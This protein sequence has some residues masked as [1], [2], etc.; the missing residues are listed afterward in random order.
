MRD[1]QPG[2]EERQAP[3]QEFL[4]VHPSRSPSATDQGAARQAARLQRRAGAAD[5]GGLPRPVARRRGYAVRAACHVPQLPIP[6][7]A[8][9]SARA[10]AGAARQT[11]PAAN[12][13]IPEREAHRRALGAHGAVSSCRASSSPR[14][15]G[16][17]G[18]PSAQSG[19]PGEPAAR[20]AALL[21]SPSR[22]TKHGGYWRPW[23]ATAS[24]RSS[25]WRWASG[26]ARARHAAFSGAMWTSTTPPSPSAASFSARHGKGSCSSN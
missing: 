21:S 23:R 14:A 8:P 3:P 1:G 17:M 6:G 25:P 2:L 9:H 24:Q 15:G 26:S 4:G 11:L 5:G 16:Q 12:S 20:G 10:G 18:P 13:T 19:A 22:R 7:D